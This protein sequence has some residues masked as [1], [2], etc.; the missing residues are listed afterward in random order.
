MEVS[1]E[2]RVGAAMARPLGSGTSVI[3]GA[4]SPASFFSMPLFAVSFF[5]ATVEDT[6]SSTLLSKAPSK[7]RLAG[8]CPLV[9]VVLILSFSSL[10]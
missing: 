1:C 6:L 4:L 10:S 8:S 3:Y 2:S 9:P 7:V 5:S